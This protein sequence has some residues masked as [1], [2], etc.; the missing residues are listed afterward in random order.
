M[1]SALSKRGG[2]SSTRARGRGSPN[3]DIKRAINEGV[4][5]VVG[6]GQI[7][8][9]NSQVASNFELNGDK[10]RLLLETMRGSPRQGTAADDEVAVLKEM[11]E[12]QEI[13]DY[14]STVQPSKVAEKR[15]SSLASRPESSLNRGANV[16]RGPHIE[17]RALTSKVHKMGGEYTMSQPNLRLT[18]LAPPGHMSVKPSATNS[19]GESGS[20]NARRSPSPHTMTTPHSAGGNKA[21]QG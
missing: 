3:Q 9:T 4:I 12:L 1:T 8:V 5:V 10:A 15:T 19:G 17:F 14:K 21:H 6:E 11:K 13:Q 7:R 16:K 2:G 18:K 20:R